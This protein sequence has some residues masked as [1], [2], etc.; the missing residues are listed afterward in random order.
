MFPVRRAVVFADRVQVLQVEVLC[1]CG[2]KATHNARTV[3]GEMVVEGEQVV[4]GDTFSADVVAYEVLCRRHHAEAPDGRAQPRPPTS[5]RT[6]PFSE[7]GDPRGRALTM[8]TDTW[9]FIT[10]PELRESSP[11]T[12]RPRSSGRPLDPHRPGRGRRGPR[13][14][15][16]FVDPTPTRLTRR[17]GRPAPA[18]RPGAVRGGVRRCGVTLDRPV[19]VTDG[20]ATAASRPARLWLLVPTVTTTSVPRRRV[21]RVGRRRAPRWRTG[22]DGAPYD[23]AGPAA[24]GY[25]FLA[26]EAPPPVVDAEG[27]AAPP[28]TGSSSTRARQRGTPARS[29]RSTRSPATSP[30]PCRC[31]CRL[32]CSARRPGRRPRELQRR[33]ALSAPYPVPRRRLLRLGA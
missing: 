18:A 11:A 32:R 31:R 28:E 20:G 16:V 23:D 22:D 33:F 14:R 7:Q 10:V 9:P 5:A 6:P 24:D 2:A 17:R 26:L 1:W 30:G 29:S 25:P 21:R 27:A 15:R 12:P 8:S 13:V 4:V 19:V 3:N